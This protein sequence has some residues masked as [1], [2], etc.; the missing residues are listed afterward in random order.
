VA[1]NRRASVSISSAIKQSSAVGQF[2]E[3]DPGS[4]TR[5]LPTYSSDQRSSGPSPS[6]KE[7]R[8]RAHHAKR[9]TPATE[10]LLTSVL[11]RSGFGSRITP[12]LRRS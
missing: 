11:R 7:S 6:H 8:R 4:P 1:T 10:Q 5:R 9:F 2:R 3:A 12:A